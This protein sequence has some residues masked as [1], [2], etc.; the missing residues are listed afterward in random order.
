MSLY[1]PFTVLPDTLCGAIELPALAQCQ[2][3]TTYIQLR[4]QVGGLLIL[5][6]GATPP[7]DWQLESDWSGVVDNSN[8]DNTKAKYLVG[9]GSFLQNTLVEVNLSGGRSLENRERFYRLTFVVLNMN[10]GHADFGRK[11]QKNVKNFDVWILTIGDRIIGGEAGMRPF[12]VNSDFVFAD[13]NDD[14]EQMVVVMDFVF[15]QFPA[16]TSMPADLNGT[17]IAPAP[18]GTCDCDIQDIL[19]G[20]VT[21]TNDTAA[22]SAGLAIGDVYI[23]GEGH[24]RASLGT[25]T[26]RLS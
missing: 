26:T 24:D 6:A 1:N 12:Y 22:A 2:D 18:A 21:Y 3:T 10:D 4:S 25:L 8:T 5:P 9:R 15:E 11:L 14:R 13:G 16:M 7:N 23:A 20:L 19:G 17:P